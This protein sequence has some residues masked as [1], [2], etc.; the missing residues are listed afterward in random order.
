[1]RARNSEHYPFHS[2]IYGKVLI[3]DLMAQGITPAQIA[4]NTAIRLADFDAPDP[5]V[6][7]DILALLYERAAELLDDDLLGFKRG[8]RREMQRGGLIAFLG[9]SSPTVETFLTNLARYQRVYSDAVDIDIGRLASDGLVEWYFN[10]PSAIERR[11]IVEFGTVAS[12]QDLRRL[13]GRQLHPVRVEFRHHR[14]TNISDFERFFG[15]PVVFGTDK[16]RVQYKRTNLALPLRTADNYLYRTVEQYCKDVLAKRERRATP[17]VVS[18]ENEISGRLVSGDASQVGVAR[19]LGMSPRTLSR[20]LADEGTTYSAVVDGYRAAMAKRL[21]R[22][23]GLPM[24]EI[25]YLLGYSEVSTFSTAFKRWTG[26]T[27]S[28]FRANQRS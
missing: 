22:D 15:C 12:L 14:S 25:A 6:S 9:M 27:A 21:I 16:N 4:G 26:Q 23:A 3:D 7:F 2:A 11:Q 24:V 28:A 1:M 20:R 5:R 18:V 8:Q 19:A 10:V 17:I 13:T